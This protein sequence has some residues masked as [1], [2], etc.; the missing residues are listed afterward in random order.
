MLCIKLGLSRVRAVL[1]SLGAPR[2]WV[3]DFA[4]IPLL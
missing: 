2:V 4:L 3:W 1:M